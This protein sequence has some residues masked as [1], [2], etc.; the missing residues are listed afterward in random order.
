MNKSTS[1]RFN[2]SGFAIGLG[3]GAALCASNGPV[4][5]IPMG[6]GLAIV[7]GLTSKRKC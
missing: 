4:L 1:S 2:L 3:V 6:I 7:F 5:G